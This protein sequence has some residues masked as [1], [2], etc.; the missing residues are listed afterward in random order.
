M[1]TGERGVTLSGGQKQRVAIARALV[2]NPSLLV[3][4]EA[5]S[6]L[7]A[8]SEKVKT[9]TGTSLH[10]PGVIQS[11]IYILYQVVQEALDSVCKGRTVLVIAHRLSTVKNANLIAVISKGKIAEMGTHEE[12]KRKGGI[13]SYLIR[14]QEILGAGA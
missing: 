4:D 10:F 13:Y 8:E 1:I 9:H 2:K 12:L 11:N 14:Q 5:T 6:A 3:L 7:D